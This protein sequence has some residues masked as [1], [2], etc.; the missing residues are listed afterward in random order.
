[1]IAPAG[2]LIA[3]IKLVREVGRVIGMQYG[4][5]GIFVRPDDAV[6]R[7]V[8]GYGRRGPRVDELSRGLRGRGSRELC[9][10]DTKR[11]QGSVHRTVVDTTMEVSRRGPNAPGQRARQT[12]PDVVPNAPGQHARQLL[13]DVVRGRVE[14]SHGIAI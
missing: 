10:R 5:V 7:A 6:S 1:M 12:L 3:V 13:P 4:R 2:S 11:F 14:M 8:G 9:V